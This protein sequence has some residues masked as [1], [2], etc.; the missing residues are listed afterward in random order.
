ME[1]KVVKTRY[2]YDNVYKNGQK[3]LLEVDVVLQTGVYSNFNKR[4]IQILPENE[5]KSFVEELCEDVK[6][7]YYEPLEMK[8]PFKFNKYN[9]VFEN[10]DETLAHCGQLVKGV[11]VKM[12][13]ELAG[14]NTVENKMYWLVHRVTFKK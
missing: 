3:I 2:G 9:V 13:I 6:I 7:S 4:Y 10:T 12:T 5:F 14:I 11:E 8:L 1:I